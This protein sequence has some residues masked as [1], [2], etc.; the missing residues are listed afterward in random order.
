MRVVIL[1]ALLLLLNLGW[2]KA[3]DT[4]TN[5][6]DNKLPNIIIILADDM[7][8]KRFMEQ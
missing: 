7:V 3:N 1:S 4:N 8:S 5:K 2:V 6:V